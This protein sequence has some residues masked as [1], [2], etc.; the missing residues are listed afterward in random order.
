VKVVIVRLLL[1]LFLCLLSAGPMPLLAQELTTGDTISEIRIEGNQRIEPSTIISYMQI[2]PGESFDALKVDQALKNLFG[3]GLFADVSFRREGS[4]LVVRVAENPIINRLAFE[5]N[6]R[7]DDETLQAEVQLRPR[8]VY[9]GPRCKATANTD[10]Y[11]Q[12]PVCRDCRA[13]VI[14]LD[15]NR[16]DLVFSKSRKAKSRRSG[17]SISPAMRITAT[18]SAVRDPDNER[19]VPVLFHQRYL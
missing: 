9:T 2:S 10:I 4:V 7:I 13:K 5:G 12:R 6:R 16:V 15:Q 17:A 19:L 14:P 8:V 3:T 18:D 11:R 1:G